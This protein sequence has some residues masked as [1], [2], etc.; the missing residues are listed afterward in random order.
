MY[1]TAI[2]RSTNGLPMGA[3]S[4]IS[5]TPY[6]SASG[7]P[8]LRLGPFCF[9][10]AEA[11][12]SLTVGAY[13]EEPTTEEQADVEWNSYAG[14]SLLLTSEITI[15]PDEA[16]LYGEPYR[17]PKAKVSMHP[18]SK[19]HA[20]KSHLCSFNLLCMVYLTFCPNI[21]YTCPPRKIY[22]FPRYIIFVADSCPP[23]LC[24]PT[25]VVTPS[26]PELPSGL[27]PRRRI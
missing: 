9:P 12:G 20:V 16:P 14:A 15:Y 2:K 22:T 8:K 18:Q 4:G 24:E 26:S 11:K 7:S 19:H 6:P 27:K 23:V 5:P 1:S 17:C 21:V 13:K 10:E 3:G 25:P